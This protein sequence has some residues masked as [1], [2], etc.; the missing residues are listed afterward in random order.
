VLN[1]IKQVT[2]RQV[3]PQ[4]DTVRHR[5]VRKAF[6]CNSKLCR[7]HLWRNERITAWLTTVLTNLPQLNLLKPSGS[8]L[9]TTGF[10]IKKFYMVLTLQLC[11]LYSSQ[12]KRRILIYT[13]RD[14]LCI[15]EGGVC[16]LRGRH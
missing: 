14:W 10:N 4:Y 9:L 11:V 3:L 2:K 15:T 7:V 13:L 16:L 12:E 6:S 1:Q 5:L 8:T